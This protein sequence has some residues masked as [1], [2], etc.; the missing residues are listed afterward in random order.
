MSPADDPGPGGIPAAA[1][2]NASADGSSPEAAAEASP[3]ATPE[4]LRKLDVAAFTFARIIARRMAR[5][6]FASC[7]A[8]ANDNQP[9][10]PDEQAPS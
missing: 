4:T 8:A 1:N 10:Q 9:E 6:D 2:D 7:M 5:E 3:E